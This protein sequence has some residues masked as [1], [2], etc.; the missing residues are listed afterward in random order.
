M[1][2]LCDSPRIREMLRVPSTVL[3]DKKNVLNVFETFMLT[4]FK[5]PFFPPTYFLPMS[6][7][8]INIR[9]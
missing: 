4:F 3:F 2:T 5:R 9:Q 6:P 7:L 8:V 1:L